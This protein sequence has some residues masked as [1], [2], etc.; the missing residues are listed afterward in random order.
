MKAKIVLPIYLCL[1]LMLLLPG[2]DTG[3]L[4]TQDATP[5]HTQE[6]TSAHTQGVVTPVA[7]FDP[8]A[9]ELPEGIAVDRQGNLYVSMTGLGEIW[10]LAPDG[11]FAETLAHFAL[12]PGDFGVVGLDFDPQGNLYAAVVTSNPDANGVWK[13]T[14]GGAKERLAGTSG[15]VLPNDIAISP[16]GTIYITDSVTGAVW[17]YVAGGQAEI[18]IQH[19]T[20]EGDATSGLNIPIGANG[21]AVT[22]KKIPFTHRPSPPSVGTVLVANLEKGQ[23][24]S[25]PIL[26]DGSAGEPM[27]V[28]ADPATLYGIDGITVDAQG[29]IYGVVFFTHTLIRIHRDGRGYDTI[30]SGEPFDFPASLTFGTGREQHTLFITNFAFGHFLSDPPMPGNANPGVVSVHVGPPGKAR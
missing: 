1:G 21:I 11:T 26:P 5:A 19:E 4:S 16:D 25:I 20:L 3:T 30:A 15:I 9:G 22:S 23:V 18:W 8:F 27:V 10:K 24:V 6:A 14:P 12:N 28:V 17:R 13:I 2:C 7:S 29:T